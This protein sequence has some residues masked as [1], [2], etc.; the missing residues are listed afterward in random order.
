MANES[1][2][3][4][5]IIVGAGPAGAQTALTLSQNN[6]KCLILD[7]H[8]IKKEENGQWR[9]KVC[10]GALTTKVVTE[11]PY[12][13]DFI[14]TTFYKN[15]FYYGK[16]NIPIHFVKKE[17][18]GYF[19]TRELFDKRLLNHAI[20]ASKNGNTQLMAGKGYKVVDIKVDKEKA[21]VYCR[22]GEIFKGRFVVGSDGVYSLV[23]RKSGLQKYWKKNVVVYRN[24]VRITK[25]DANKLYKNGEFLH[26]YMY[27]GG[28]LGYGWVFANVDSG[29]IN[30]GYGP[31]ST[32]LKPKESERIYRKFFEYN[33]NKKLPE[34][35]RD[36]FKTQNPKAWKLSVDGCIKK[37]TS[38]RVLLVGDSAG[39]S[40]PGSGEGIYFSLYA[41]KKSA[42]CISLYLRGKISLESMY[43]RYQL[44]CDKK[45]GRGHRMMG[46][47]LRSPLG[48]KID[49]LFALARKDEE[50]KGLIRDILI[51]E[52]SLRKSLFRVLFRLVLAV[53]RSNPNLS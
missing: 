2:I 9:D 16:S 27:W 18:I 3:Y 19:I 36:F 13:E 23:R 6:H 47:I 1:I 32:S 33:I 28:F 22:N 51:G 20:S 52:I 14:E 34:T 17:P 29:H 30:I 5:V 21:L 41:G 25:E 42:E 37:I 31:L 39:M 40:N 10:G 44:A 24:L 7:Q 11:F 45:F 50:L 8:E 26:I 48:N 12:I 49:G 35:A 38:D 15:N 43:K 46:K 53:L 4:D